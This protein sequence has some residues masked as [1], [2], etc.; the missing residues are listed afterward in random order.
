M[1]GNLLLAFPW[2]NEQEVL[3][4]CPS[5]SRGPHAEPETGRFEI[6]HGHRDLDADSINI[7]GKLVG[8]AFVTSPRVWPMSLHH[9]GEHLPRSKTSIVE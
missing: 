6:G 1:A 2:E 3:D 5:K 9:R 8:D 7:R 4:H